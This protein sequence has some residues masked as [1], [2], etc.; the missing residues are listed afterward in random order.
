[1]HEV[2]LWSLEKLPTITFHL[3]LRTPYFEFKSLDA[4][5]S[6][7]VLV[8]AQNK[9]GKSS[10]FVLQAYTVKNPEKQTGTLTQ[11]A[12]FAELGFYA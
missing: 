10:P 7:Q 11:L 9:K 5:M 6:Y 2:A 3:F 8:V 4:G 12:R 1:M